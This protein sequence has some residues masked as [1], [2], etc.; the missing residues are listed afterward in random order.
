[1]KKGEQKK[2]ALVVVRTIQVLS[3]AIPAHKAMGFQ[4]DSKINSMS[5]E[6]KALVEYHVGDKLKEIEAETTKIVDAVK[7]PFVAELEK[8]L[9]S[10]EDEDEKTGMRKT[11]DMK[12]NAALNANE[13]YVKLREDEKAI[14]GTEVALDLKT[15][16]IEPKDYDERFKEPKPIEFNGREITIDGYSALLQLITLGVIKVNWPKEADEADEA[17]VEDEADTIIKKLNKTVNKK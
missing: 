9:E 15:I 12:I 14:W 3:S 16:E 10:I 13:G 6:A 11:A 5:A 2:V 8:A 17:D 7:K 1:M 4:V